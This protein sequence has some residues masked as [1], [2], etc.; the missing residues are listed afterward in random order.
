MTAEDNA[1]AHAL[2]FSWWKGDPDFTDEEARLH[3]L[4]ALH[5]ATV[6]LVR[7]HRDLLGYYDSDAEL[8]V[9]GVV[10]SADR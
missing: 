3:D 5:R 9:G 6:E 1:R 10:D 4:V 8:F 7:E 2:E